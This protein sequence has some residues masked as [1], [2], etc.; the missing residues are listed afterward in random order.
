MSWEITLSDGAIIDNLEL[1]GNNFI[2]KAEITSEIFN[3]KLS[4]VVIEGPEDEYDFGL[5][6]EH[7]N[8]KLARCCK[9]DGLG[10]WAFVLIDTPPE[11]LR[12]LEVDSRLDYIE[13]MEGL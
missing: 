13:M 2:S 8:M 7:A 6:G 4:H 1:N 9:D 11:E 12:Q 10:G 3:G 5:R